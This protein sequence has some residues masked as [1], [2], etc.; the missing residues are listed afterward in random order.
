M[1]RKKQRSFLLRPRGQSSERIWRGSNAAGGAVRLQ[2]PEWR[3]ADFVKQQP[4]RA[5]QNS[6]ARAGRNFSQPR[7]NLYF[8]LCIWSSGIRSFRFY[9]QL[10]VNF[11]SQVYTIDYFRNMVILNSWSFFA[12]SV[13][14]THM[15]CPWNTYCYLSLRTNIDAPIHALLFITAEVK[16]V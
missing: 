8:P 15:V 12:W 16:L 9:G 14:G 10:L 3:F 4:G 2:G 6:Q 1:L 7:T 11:W 13:H 5:R